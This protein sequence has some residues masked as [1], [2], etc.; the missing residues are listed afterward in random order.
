MIS[1]DTAATQRVPA[2]KGGAPAAP[3]R[4]KSIPAEKARTA[5][6]QI[7]VRKK[8]N[9]NGGCDRRALCIGAGAAA[10]ASLTSFS[11]FCAKHPFLDSRNAL[12]CLH[13]EP[14]R[15]FVQRA[16]GLT[17]VAEA[18]FST[19]I[20]SPGHHRFHPTAG[21]SPPFP[22]KSSH[23]PGICR[24]RPGDGR[25]A[26][27]RPRLHRSRCHVF[28]YPRA[29]PPRAQMRPCP[30]GAKFNTRGNLHTALVFR[31]LARNPRTMAQGE[32]SGG[33]ST[34]APL[35]K[36]WRRPSICPRKR[37]PGRSVKKKYLQRPSR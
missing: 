31:C 7:T 30:C 12:P 3:G 17:L 8:N 11:Q 10:C 13:D 5:R 4:K 37:G 25:A 14:F 24:S 33:L 23:R 9:E 19:G 1:T 16:R 6:L 35:N 21:P 34:A 27:F 29:I 26:R 20:G 28:L 18:V 36:R 22:M 15:W 2:K 32:P